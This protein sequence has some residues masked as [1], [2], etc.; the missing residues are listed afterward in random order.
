MKKHKNEDKL[1]KLALQLGKAYA[2]KRGYGGLEKAESNK[3]KVEAIYRLLV[4]DKL[5]S[6]LP[7]DKEDGPNL[8]HRLVLWIISQL[9]EN[10]ELLQ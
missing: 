9:P 7:E 4:H 10:H 1:L 8:K 2:T 6:P 5:I 3:D